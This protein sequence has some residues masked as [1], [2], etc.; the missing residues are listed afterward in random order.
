MNKLELGDVNWVKEMTG[1]G[2][3]TSRQIIKDTHK[4]MKRKNIVMYPSKKL[5]APK[6]WIKV[7]LGI[8]EKEKGE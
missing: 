3:H 2:I 4:L 7:H 8:I 6:Y 5:R 1:Y